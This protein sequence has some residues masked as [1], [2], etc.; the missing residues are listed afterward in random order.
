VNK[1]SEKFGSMSIK[2]QCETYLQLIAVNKIAGA[3]VHKTFLAG[4]KSDYA[5]ANSKS[6]ISIDDWLKPYYDEPLFEK[7]LAK[8]KT[9]KEELE[10]TIKG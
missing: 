10:A 1:A 2:R 4:M 9:N 7:V 8:C 6:P 3:N 5:E